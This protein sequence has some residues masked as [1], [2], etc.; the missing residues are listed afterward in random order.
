MDM[1]PK[2]WFRFRRRATALRDLAGLSM[3]HEGVPFIDAGLKY[4]TNTCAYSLTPSV[5][6]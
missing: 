4:E 5:Q 3:P 2:G 6:N 1:R